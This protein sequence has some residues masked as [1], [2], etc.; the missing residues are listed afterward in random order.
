MSNT[1]QPDELAHRNLL[2]KHG[3]RVTGAR[4]NVLEILHNSLSA[5]SQNEVE[6]KLKN[7]PDR[8]T[9]YRIFKDFEEAGIIH[10]LIDTLGVTKFALCHDCQEHTHHD[11]HVHFSCTEC[12]ETYCLDHL[13]LPDLK[14]PKGYEIRNIRINIEGTCLSC[15]N[16]R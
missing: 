14:L 4:L 11:D 10:K 9:L 7:P 8:V 12:Q 15:G 5:Q 3:L 2:K 16:K 6:R 1:L 13:N